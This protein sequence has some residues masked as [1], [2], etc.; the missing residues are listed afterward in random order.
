MRSRLST[1]KLPNWNAQRRAISTD[2]RRRETTGEF[3]S[4]NQH[5]GGI[6]AVADSADAAPTTQATAVFMELKEALEKL[7]NAGRKSGRRMFRR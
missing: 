5:F 4:L 6:L 7:V 2:C 1:S 3:F